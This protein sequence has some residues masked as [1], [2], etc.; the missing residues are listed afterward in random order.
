MQSLHWLRGTAEKVGTKVF[1]QD[2][3]DPE[4]EV[5]DRVSLEWLIGQLDSEERDILML[6]VVEELNFDD[7]GTIIGNR[8][9]NEPMRGTTIRYRKDKIMRKLREFRTEVGV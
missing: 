7:I 8:Y 6:W 9:H 3:R 5:L 4:D 1:F 2:A